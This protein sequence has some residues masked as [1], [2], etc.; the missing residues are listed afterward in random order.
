MKLRT[1]MLINCAVALIFGA[2][3]V[4]APGQTMA[5][6]LIPADAPLLL[7]GQ[8]FGACLVGYAVLTWLA[9]NAAE[10][11]ARRA[12]VISLCVG[13]AIGFI[14]ALLGQIRGVLTTL[15]WV[16]VAIYLLL[17]LGYAYFAFL[18]PAES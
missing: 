13:D 18:K 7:T 11:T 5:L 10:S 17:A 8:L 4:V 6:Y 3:F 16:N 2:A 14:V 1:L 12:I 9:R 15:G